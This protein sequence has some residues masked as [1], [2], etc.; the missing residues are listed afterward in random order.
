M[1]AVS[2]PLHV[3]PVHPV[4]PRVGAA[5]AI[6]MTRGLVQCLTL[7]LTMFCIHFIYLKCIVLAL[8]PRCLIPFCLLA[9][10]ARCVRDVLLEHKF[11]TWNDFALHSPLIGL[12]FTLP[13]RYPLVVELRCVLVAFVPA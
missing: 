2:S 1:V 9:Y 4:R 3:A 11:P 8:C 10:R 6:A 12:T 5:A 7:L 13:S